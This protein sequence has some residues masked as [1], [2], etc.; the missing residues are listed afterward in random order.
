M[1]PVLGQQ[2]F[3]PMITS[4]PDSKCYAKRTT[5]NPID[6]CFELY[7]VTDRSAVI[8]FAS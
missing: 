6:K 3:K 7:E 8:S 4:V 1:E 2:D 5:S